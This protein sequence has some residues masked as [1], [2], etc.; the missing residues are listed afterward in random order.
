MTKT[1]KY[2]DLH[3]LLEEIRASEGMPENLSTEAQLWDEIMKKETFLMP[4]QL[5]PLIK[6]VHGKAF[7]CADSVF[8]APVSKTAVCIE[9]RGR[10][11]KGGID[12]LLSATYTGI[13]RR[14]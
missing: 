7:V 13:R 9:K 12:F 4:E 1:K 2:Y 6:E 3:A 11:Q 5:F 14:G 8:T 10:Y